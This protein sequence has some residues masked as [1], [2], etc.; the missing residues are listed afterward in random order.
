[1]YNLRAASAAENGAEKAELGVIILGTSKSKMRLTHLRLGGCQNNDSH[2]RWFQHSTSAQHFSTAEADYQYTN[3][4]SNKLRVLSPLVYNIYSVIGVLVWEPAHKMA[5][6]LRIYEYYIYACFRILIVVFVNLRSVSLQT[7]ERKEVEE[8]CWT[9]P[10]GR[11]LQ[12]VKR[13]WSEIEW[14]RH[15]LR[16]WPRIYT[17]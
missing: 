1:M 15:G 11:V 14:Q 8:G 17:L 12:D 7:C 5:Q 3:F 6:D 10:M 4:N 9:R 16:G 2:F 13:E